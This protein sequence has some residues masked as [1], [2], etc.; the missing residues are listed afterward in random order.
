MHIASY[1]HVL[2]V[3]RQHDVAKKN[4]EKIQGQLK[5]SE[6]ELSTMKKVHTYNIQTSMH[7]NHNIGGYTF[8]FI[9]HL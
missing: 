4:L 5:A 7:A 9:F 3:T 2:D 6:T 1:V 8:M